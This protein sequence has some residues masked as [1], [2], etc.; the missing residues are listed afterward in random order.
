MVLEFRSN[1][2]PLAP[3]LG[4]I[5]GKSAKLLLDVCEDVLVAYFLRQRVKPQ[6]EGVP[7]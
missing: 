1:G 7:E 2:F 4:Q 5:G 3:R 6:R